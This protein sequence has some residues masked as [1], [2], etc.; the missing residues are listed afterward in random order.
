[1]IQ[2]GAARIGV[3]TN[4]D[5]RRNRTDHVLWRALQS[6]PEIPRIAYRGDDDLAGG[7]AEMARAGVTDIV[8]DGGDGTVVAVVS[9]A[10]RVAEFARLPRL[11][12]VPSGMTNLIADEMGVAVPRREVIDRLLA[13]S[14][15]ALDAATVTHAPMRIERG[16]GLPDLHGFL[17]GGAAF[18]RGTLLSWERVHPLGAT[19]HAAAGLGI[20][21]NIWR[22]AFGAD[23][24]AFLA[25]DP[26]RVEVDG[27]PMPSDRQ[28]LV[29]L[30]TL[31]RLV[32]RLHPFWG[33]G[34]GGI[35]WLSVSAPPQRLLRAL[36]RVLLGRPARW[37]EDAGYRSGRASRIRLVTSRPVVL[38]GEIIEPGPA[39]AFEITIERPFRFLRLT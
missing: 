4:P 22:A 1:M 37:M 39:G 8:V 32:L 19:Q 33:D 12:V 28:F 27:A 36:P 25:G 24:K 5:A 6:R 10:L 31:D 20:L 16:A 26:I 3:V 18:H 35:R 7:L 21:A 2:Q 29:L 30:S 11:A 14:A 15:A 13:T 38:D 23:R 17:L 9:A 34:N